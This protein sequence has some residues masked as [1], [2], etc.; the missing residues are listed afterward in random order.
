MSVWYKSG[1]LIPLCH[2]RAQFLSKTMPVISYRWADMFLHYND[3][4]HCCLFLSNSCIHYPA[5]IN[6][7]STCINP[8]LKIVPRKSTLYSRF[9]WNHFWKRN[10]FVSNFQKFTSSVGMNGLGADVK[11]RLIKLKLMIMDTPPPKKNNNKKK[12]IGNTLF[13]LT[14]SWGLWTTKQKQENTDYCLCYP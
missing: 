7:H 12:N 11:H 1:Y 4:R 8:H 9:Y 10:I 14:Y 5:D 3:H 13:V 6:I 2:H